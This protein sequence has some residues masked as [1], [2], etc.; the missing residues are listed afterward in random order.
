MGIIATCPE[1]SYYQDS[2]RERFRSLTANPK[3]SV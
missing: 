3:Q 2:L 1:E